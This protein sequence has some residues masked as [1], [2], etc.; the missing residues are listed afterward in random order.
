MARH[1]FRIPLTLAA[2][3]LVLGFAAACSDDEDD[4]APTGPQPVT[5]VASLSSANERPNPA[6]NSSGTGSA[7]VVVTGANGSYTVTVNGLTGAPTNAHIHGPANTTV[8]AG[9][10]V[11]LT[12]NTVT[13][14]SGTMSGSFTAASISGQG[15]QPPISLDSLMVLM[16]AGLTYVNVHTAQYPGG[17]VRGQLNLR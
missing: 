3:G 15:G 13:G 11:P 7:T 6:S 1:T 2:A 17:E 9:V 8:S 4:P 14:T 12:F 16:R 5:F 10:L